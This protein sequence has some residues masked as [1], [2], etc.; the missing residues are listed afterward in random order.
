MLSYAVRETQ[1]NWRRGAGAGASRANGRRP[2]FFVHPHI[3]I[4]IIIC[5][6]G[7]KNY[8]MSFMMNPN[9]DL[10]LT[11]MNVSLTRID[12]R[13]F[14]FFKLFVKLKGYLGEGSCENLPLVYLIQSQFFT[15]ERSILFLS[16]TY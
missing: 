11:Y 7:M 8:F 6:I 10:N 3:L 12:R 16:Q 2:T 13:C 15:S 4:I 14:F 9:F 5:T 1:A